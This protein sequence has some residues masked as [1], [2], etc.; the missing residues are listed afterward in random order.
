LEN[1]A[2]RFH[3]IQFLTDP[4]S[5]KTIKELTG[6]ICKFFDVPEKETQWLQ[7]WLEH[8]DWDNGVVFVENG[9]Y[10][11][12]IRINPSPHTHAPWRL[13]ITFYPLENQ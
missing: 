4:M 2:D 5:T 1:E 12:S 3:H 7:N 10:K 13:G 9:I 8:P 11:I 6:D